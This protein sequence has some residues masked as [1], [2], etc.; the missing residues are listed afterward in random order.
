MSRPYG[1][2]NIPIPEPP[3]TFT[4]GSAELV[5][6]AKLDKENEWVFP[7]EL[8]GEKLGTW[9]LDHFQDFAQE[10]RAATKY[11]EKVQRE[12]EKLASK[13]AKLEED[14]AFLKR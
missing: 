11:P 5:I 4:I 2:K 1:S 7:I 10:V 6:E 8:G 13:I 14:L 3:F 9:D 12:R